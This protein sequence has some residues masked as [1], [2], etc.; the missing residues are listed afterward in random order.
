MSEMIHTTL[1]FCFW[2]IPAL[3]IL[4]AMVV[5]LIVHI[6]KQKKRE[7]NLE[8]EL[9]NSMAEQVAKGRDSL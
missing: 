9:A 2:D 3:I 8:E 1:G 7:R 4:V 6:V 5:V